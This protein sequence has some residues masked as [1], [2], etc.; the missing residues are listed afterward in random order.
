MRMAAEHENPQLECV[1]RQL[2][3]A[4]G[5]HLGMAHPMGS[6]FRD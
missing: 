1:V 4:A 6:M 5:L 2:A 3:S